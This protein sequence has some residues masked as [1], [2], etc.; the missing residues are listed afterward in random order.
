MILRVEQGWIQLGRAFERGDR[1]LGVTLLA[2]DESQSI[3]R[4][5]HR[6]G[7]LDCPPVFAFC[8]GGVFAL[9]EDGAQVV[10]R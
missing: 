3:V 9:F 10:V 7:E 8:G 1:L 2:E 5:R 6:R 4:G